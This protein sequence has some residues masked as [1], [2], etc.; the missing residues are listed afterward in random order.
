MA[1]ATTPEALPERLAAF[2][3]IGV[4]TLLVV[5]CGSDRRRRCAARARGGRRA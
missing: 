4:D 3:A 1:L 2:E 5:P